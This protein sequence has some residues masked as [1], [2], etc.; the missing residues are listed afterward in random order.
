[1]LMHADHDHRH[2]DAMASYVLRDP[3]DHEVLAMKRK[4]SFCLRDNRRVRGVPTLVR[5][6]YFGECS[7][8][9]H[10][11]ISPGWI[12]VYSADL[13]GQ[14]LPLPSGRGPR[15][16]CLDLAADPRELAKEVN[17]TDNGTSIGLR[18]AGLGVRRA[19]GADC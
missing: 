16:L 7:R 5:R 17:E 1:M 4:V 18:V 11:G 2:F 8:R 12:D 14:S 6:E 19:P 3:A 9:T 13:P 10:Q 15:L